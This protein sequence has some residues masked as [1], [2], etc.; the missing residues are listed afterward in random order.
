VFITQ[1]VNY[2]RPVSGLVISPDLQMQF[3]HQQ[4]R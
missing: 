4:E 3:L 2:D 1:T